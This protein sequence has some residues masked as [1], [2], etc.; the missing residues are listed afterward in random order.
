[1]LD[2]KMGFLKKLMM[3]HLQLKLLII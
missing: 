3:I 1:M 2:L